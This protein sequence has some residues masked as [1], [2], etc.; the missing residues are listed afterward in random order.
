MRRYHHKLFLK[1]TEDDTPRDAEGNF[2]KPQ[3]QS[4]FACFCRDEPNGNGRKTNLPDGTQIDYASVVYAPLECPDLEHGDEI[5]VRDS[6]DRIRV[7]G[8]VVRF[9]RELKYCQIWV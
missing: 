5:Y 1:T 4:T 3:L 6:R 2:I 7:Q 8:S 9:T